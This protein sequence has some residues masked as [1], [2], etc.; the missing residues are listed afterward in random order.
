MFSQDQKDNS[1]PTKTTNKL[2]KLGIICVTLAFV[3]WGVILITPFLPY[4]TTTKVVISSVF[5][6]IGEISF[7][8][9]GFILGREVIARYRKYLNPFNWFKKKS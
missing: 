6:V 5:A 1:L 9:G 7:W 8:V 4:A 2:R 3:F